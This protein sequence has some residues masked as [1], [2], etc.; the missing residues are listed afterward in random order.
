MLHLRDDNRLPGEDYPGG[1]D[2]KNEKL[3]EYLGQKSDM[4]FKT[5]NN[6]NNSIFFQHQQFPACFFS[7]TFP[8]VCA[9]KRLG[10][11]KKNGLTREGG[12]QFFSL[13]KTRAGYVGGGL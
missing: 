12:S 7:L 6:N 5:V 9:S 10:K 3:Q 1:F 8:T 13:P 11:R 4:V 2:F